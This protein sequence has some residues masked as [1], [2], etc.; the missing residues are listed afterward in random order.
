VYVTLESQVNGQTVD[1]HT[2]ILTDLGLAVEQQ[3]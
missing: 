1:V 2:H 3:P